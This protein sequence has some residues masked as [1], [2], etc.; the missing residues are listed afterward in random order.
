MKYSN[1]TIG[2]RTRDFQTCS[3]VS[4]PTE[5]QRAPLDAVT[6]HI[7]DRRK[8]AIGLSYTKPFSSDWFHLGKSVQ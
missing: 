6:F 7:M 8:C 1:D 5:Q 3:A 4:Q 2:N